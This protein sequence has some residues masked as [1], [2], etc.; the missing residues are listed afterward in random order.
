LH[1]E[2]TFAEFEEVLAGCCSTAGCLGG[3]PRSVT[4]LEDQLVVHVA[5]GLGV[6]AFELDGGKVRQGIEMAR[7]IFLTTT[8]LPSA[9][10]PRPKLRTAP[11]TNNAAK[12]RKSDRKI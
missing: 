12:N 11:T 4:A 1:G 8:P 2:Q 5:H 9:S 6:H 10:R 7:N 3:D